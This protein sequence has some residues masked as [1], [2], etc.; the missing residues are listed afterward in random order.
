MVFPTNQLTWTTV[1]SSRDG[2]LALGV[3][4]PKQRGEGCSLLGCLL[5]AGGKLCCVQAVQGSG[6]PYVI[7]GVCLGSTEHLP[8]METGVRT[9]AHMHT[10]TE[11]TDL[12]VSQ[13]PLPSL[14]PAGHY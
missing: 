2:F 13:A 9:V 7:C 8:E 12:L 3:S 1:P 10:G 6:K 14:L 4:D 5:P 11:S